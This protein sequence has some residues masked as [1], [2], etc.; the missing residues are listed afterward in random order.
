MMGLLTNVHAS[1]NVKT[2]IIKQANGTR[3]YSLDCH[4][5]VGKLIADEKDRKEQIAHLNKTIKLKDLSI[6]LSYKRA[7][8]WQKEAENQYGLLKKHA[9]W[10]SYEKYIWFGGG[11]A[12]TVLSVWASGQIK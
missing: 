6:D 12:V 11:I 5:M 2:D 4:K 8:L 1:C 10:R 3:I 9:K 7:D